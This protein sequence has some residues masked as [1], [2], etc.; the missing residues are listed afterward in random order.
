MPP[1][2]EPKAGGR[3]KSSPAK[4]RGG[5]RS[6][7]EKKAFGT[8]SSYQP[9][10]NFSSIP[11]A[12]APAPA[13]SNS[14]LGRTASEDARR[15]PPPPPGMQTKAKER[16]STSSSSTKVASGSSRGVSGSDSSRTLVGKGKGKEREVI[17][18]VDDDEDDATATA[19]SPKGG[20]ELWTDIYGPTSEAELAP[21]KARIAKVKSWLHESHHG[22]PADY[23]PPPQGVSQS[24]RDKLRKY[25]RILLL[26]G[27][28]GVGKATTVRL[29]AREMGIELLEWGEAVEE[30]SLGGGFDRE[31]AMSKLSSFLLRHSYAP[32]NM[33]TAS[34]GG[35]SSPA[36]PR[37]LLM[38]SLPNITH[39][40]T[41]EAF[42]A[43]LLEFCQTYT[44]SSCP[45][46]I[47][48]SNA[49]SG[50]KA[51]ESWMDRDRGGREGAL[52][53]LGREVKDGPW[54]TE[55]DFLALAHTFLIKAINRVLSL[56]LPKGT[57]PPS[58]SAIHLIALSA[59]GDLRSAINSLQMLCSRKLPKESKKR[60]SDEMDEGA[61]NKGAGAG[62]GAGSKKGLKGGRAAKVDAS[63][64][65]RAVLDAV[66]RREQS[67][68]LFHAL[69]K[70]FYNKRLG[71][72]GEDEEDQELLNVIRS[73]PP[74]DP[75]PDHLADHARCKSLVQM[76]AFVPTV[77]VDASSFAL[78]IH[79]SLPSFCTEIEQASEAVDDLCRA[80]I[81]RTDDDIWQSS[82]QS[83]SYAL[84]LTI[85]G[86]HTALPSPVPRKH[87]KILK[88]EFFEKFSTERTNLALLD[89]AAGYLARKAM[90][91]SVALSELRLDD[92]SRGHAP[93]GGMLSKGVLAGEVLPMMIKLQG[94]TKQW[95]RGVADL[96]G[97]GPLLPAGVAPLR[98]PP[99]SAFNPKY[100]QELSSG[101]A[102]AEGD[103]DFEAGAAGEDGLG[104]VLSGGGWDQGEENGKTEGDEVKVL[105][106][107]DIEDWE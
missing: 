39:Q 106:D 2:R 62:V 5:S 107:D 48:H 75:L 42:H 18:V 85:R 56:A 60:K 72:P 95:V 14:S 66:T 97:A 93:W 76:E 31:S 38:T 70:V 77:P 45:L 84:H 99:Y 55:I 51:E 47:V 86:S 34:S 12:P 27:P 16:L 37:V 73:L 98:L 100:A 58:T 83:I 6:G 101:D 82:Q 78:W 28:A 96:I 49:G 74:D 1:T 40:P 104:V 3:S 41:R 32:L 44:P 29:L 103:D 10:L 81:M 11:S 33:S 53:L 79:Q 94:M 26:T 61:R 92:D 36:R 21:G 71:D 24:S 64:E 63:D 17:E 52:E 54:C 90:A 23:I 88:P 89:S 67:L 69:G 8:L 46:I 30:W 105:Q 9:K 102:E 13:R 22:F 7:D 15:M 4:N 65:L 59:N 25:R 43:A 35:R 20:A 68:N 57:T 91:S 80:D 50:G 87:Q 19:K